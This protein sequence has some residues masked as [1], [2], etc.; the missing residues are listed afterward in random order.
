MGSDAYH[1]LD[2]LAEEALRAELDGADDAAIDAF[3]LR[4]LDRPLGVDTIALER[5]IERGGDPRLRAL[6]NRSPQ[7]APADLVGLAMELGL[8]GSAMTLLDRGADPNGRGFSHDTAVMMAVERAML[9]GARAPLYKE[10]VERLLAA[11]ADPNLPDAY[12]HVVLHSLVFQSGSEPELAFELARRLLEAG[13]SLEA[14]DRDG[15]TPEGLARAHGCEWF[16]AL[17]QAL[18]ERR[19]LGES[20]ERPALARASR[21]PGL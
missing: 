4:L 19:E 11:G 6:A 3:I 17:A 18:R 8:P 2:E 12:G 7:G 9:G 16:L 5:A 1:G 13:A 15:L 20:V 10:A 21:S 14:K